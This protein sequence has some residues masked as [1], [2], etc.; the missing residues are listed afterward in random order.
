MSPGQAFRLMWALLQRPFLIWPT[1]KATQQTMQECNSLYGS[2]HHMNGKP[3]AFRHALWNILICKKTLKYTKNDHKS[4][5]WAKKV[6]DLH[7]KMAKSEVLDTMMDLHNN[8]I[9]R[10]LFLAKKD[11]NDSELKVFLLKKLEKAQK[12]TKIEDFRHMENELV[13]ILE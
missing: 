10:R 13:Y 4:A 12:V 2:T 7:E 11:Q 3:N 1:W 5:K 8:E 9:G 6:T